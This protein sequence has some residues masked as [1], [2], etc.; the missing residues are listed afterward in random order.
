MNDQIHQIYI[1]MSFQILWLFIIACLL[2]FILLLL[3]S[4]N[5]KLNPSWQK[6]QELESEFDYNERKEK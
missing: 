5:N 3:C 2:L 6:E 1:Q 4:I